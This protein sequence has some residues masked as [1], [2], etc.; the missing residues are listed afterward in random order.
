M[1]NETLKSQID[2][3]ARFIMAEVPGEPS[4]SEGAV[5]TAI[6][7]IRKTLKTPNEKDREFIMQL[8]GEMSVSLW[9]DPNT[10]KPE[11][12]V[13]NFDSERAIEYGERI[14]D[15]LKSVANR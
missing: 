4:E 2:R 3:L 15:R 13:G 6:R 1:S 7:V 12:S 11:V 8:I 14:L 9:Y 10:M 5:D